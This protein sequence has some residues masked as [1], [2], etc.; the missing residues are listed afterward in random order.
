MPNSTQSGDLVAISKNKGWDPNRIWDQ[1]KGAY[2]ESMEPWDHEREPFARNL[3][4]V[5]GGMPGLDEP[6]DA[7]GGPT[8]SERLTWNVADVSREAKV[9]GKPK[10]TLSDPVAG[11]STKDL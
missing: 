1:E 2:T 7:T 11:D 5:P 3:G 4:S 6:A 10:M 8:M 9:S